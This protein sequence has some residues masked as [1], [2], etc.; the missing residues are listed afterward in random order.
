[1]YSLI[2]TLLAVVILIYMFE[3]LRKKSSP[4]VRRIGLSAW[5][6]IGI[7]TA[8]YGIYMDRTTPGMGG[9]GYAVLGGMSL[10]FWV[11]PT[12]LL[13]WIDIKDTK[14]KDIDAQ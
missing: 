2:V 10:L 13:L 5:L 1:M 9:I 8:A 3:V 7:L 6:A 12:G 4:R 11:L 14:K